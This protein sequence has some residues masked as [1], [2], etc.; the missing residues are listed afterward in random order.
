LGKDSEFEIIVFNINLEF[1]YILR[2]R[3]IISIY[4]NG[5]ITNM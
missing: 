4:R 5:K 2:V 3:F 1:P